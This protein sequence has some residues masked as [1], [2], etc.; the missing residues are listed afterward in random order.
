MGKAKAK[1]K[2]L[3]VLPL[4]YYNVNRPVSYSGARNI[5]KAFHGRIPKEKIV[6]WLEGQDAYSLHKYVRKRFP[7]LSYDVS[8]IDD[9]WEADLIDVRNIRRFN[10]GF[11][12][13]LVVIDVLS[14]MAWVEPL[15]D[16]SC[17]TVTKAFEVILERANGRIPVC[18]QTDKGREFIGGALQQF[19]KSRD[20]RF[21]TAS[22]PD[23]K[24][25]VVERFNRTLKERMWRYFTHRN[26]KRYVEVLQKIVNAYNHTKHSGTRLLPA[27]VTML[28][29]AIARDNLLH[30]YAPKRKIGVK[31]KVGDLVRISRAKDVFSKGYKQGWTSE[32][33]EVIHIRDQRLPITYILRD[34]EDQEI[35]GFFYTEELNRVGHG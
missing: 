28:N 21:R 7:R 4:T 35:D 1:K 31:Y 16:K 10:A 3:N 5:V 26:T 17:A 25:A 8:N 19:L 29:A 13:I 2:K 22:S 14:K 9:L 11:T 33:F 34:L 18:L 27:E 24:C 32:V 30:R 15:R 20:I 6:T 12:Y 23:V